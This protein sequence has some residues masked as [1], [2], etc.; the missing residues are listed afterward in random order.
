MYAKRML[1][2]RTVK[3]KRGKKIKIITGL[4]G[5]KIRL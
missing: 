3:E 1:M 5:M 2:A 4:I